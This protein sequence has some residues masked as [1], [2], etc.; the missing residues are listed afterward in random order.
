M[1]FEKF[2]QGLVEIIIFWG[3]F[4]WSSVEFSQP[5]GNFR[6]L[7]D[8]QSR[9]DGRRGRGSIYGGAF[10]KLVGHL[11]WAEEERRTRLMDGRK[12]G[13]CFRGKRERKN[14]LGGGGG[15]RAVSQ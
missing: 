10:R 7:S 3:R 12:I 2:P 14:E 15:A 1:G 8:R 11:M 9:R 13:D 6:R 5:G 4:K